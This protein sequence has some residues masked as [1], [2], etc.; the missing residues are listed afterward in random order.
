MSAIV[1]PYK[2]TPRPYQKDRFTYMFGD[3]A[4]PKWP[5]KKRAVSVWHR[6]S[7][8]D[9]TSLNL[10]AMASHLRIGTYWHMLPT[11]N[12]G[13]KV[14]WD[15][16]DKYGR[17]IIDQAFPPEIRESTNEQEMRIKFKC[18]SAWQVVGS[19]NYDSLIG[20]NP[21][22][23]IFSE[24]SVA[25]PS[26]WDFI[27]PILLENNGYA[28]FIYTPRGKNHGY[29]TYDMAM[30]NPLWDCTLFT[31]DE[32][33]DADGKYIIS[34]EMIAEERMSGMKED[35]VQQEYYCSFDTGLVGAFYTNEMN[36][37]AGEKRIGDFP[38]IPEELVSTSWDLGLGVGNDTF[39]IHGQPDG[40]YCRVIDVDHGTGRGLNH[41]IKE[42]KA[43]P[44]VYHRHW[45][46]HD[47]NVHDYSHGV[48]RIEVARKL[49]IDFDEMPNVSRADGIEAARR[50]IHRCRFNEQ[51]CGPL[52]DALSNYRR[53]YDEKN[54]VYRINPLHD[55][56]SNGADSFRCKALSWHLNRF[57]NP[58]MRRSGSMHIPSVKSTNG[59]ISRPTLRNRTLT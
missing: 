9:S 3:L 16:I 48:E 50:F 6:R 5:E 59:K 36:R 12:Q 34:P 37:A 8:K 41:W 53:E 24:W 44:Y 10:T 31:V 4:K 20:A 49:G 25:D 46:P 51:T 35:M 52:I 22:G 54:Q 26:A 58:F 39:I 45:A 27:R 56:S 57:D 13:R 14:I 19:D 40:D 23:V 38:W 29:K 32:T 47:I 55:W 30:K 28:W 2:W 43:K 1:L 15:G 11:L 21:I 42:V 18:G 7:G 17:R 33:I